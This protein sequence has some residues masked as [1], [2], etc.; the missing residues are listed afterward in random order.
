MPTPGE[1]RIAEARRVAREC[2]KLAEPQEAPP[3]ESFDAS[4]A[5][6]R[7]LGYV[8]EWDHA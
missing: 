1:R 7:Q 4:R 5:R 3:S 2:Q 8:N 6:L